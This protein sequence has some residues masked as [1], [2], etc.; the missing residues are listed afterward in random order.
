MNRTLL[1]SIAVPALLA[2]GLG[3][4]LAGE[5]LLKLQIGTVRLILPLPQGFCK[6]TG[7]MLESAQANAAFDERNF[8]LATLIACDR[9]PLI[10]PWGNYVLVK[11]PKSAIGSTF[12]KGE[13][14]D[15]LDKSARGPDDIISNEK[16]SADVANDSERVWGQRIE[17]HS[18]FEYAGRDRDCVYLAGPFQR[19]IAG[20][21]NVTSGQAATC[22]TVVGGRFFAVNVYEIP[23]VQPIS[24]LKQQAHRIA[25]SIH[26]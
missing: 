3:T 15:A 7:A 10:A 5:K 6:P 9:T 11:V 19:N 17:M 8:T 26:R 12:P 20:S 1:A 14:L 2:A 21:D 22:M 18:K 16:M 13:F 24:D 23:A 4:A 25:L